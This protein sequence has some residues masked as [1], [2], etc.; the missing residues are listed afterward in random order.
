ME[1]RWKRRKNEMQGGMKIQ[2]ED[3]KLRKG[4]GKF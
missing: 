2:N 1:Q 3:D 4:D